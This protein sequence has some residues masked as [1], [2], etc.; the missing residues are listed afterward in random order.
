MGE[1]K[2]DGFHH[3]FTKGLLLLNGKRGIEGPGG[4]PGEAFILGGE[5]F[6]D[7]AFE[8]GFE[9]GENRRDVGA[10]AAGIELLDQRI[11]RCDFENFAAKL[12]FFA[13]ESHDAIKGGQKILPVSA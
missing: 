10:A 9:L 5:G 1:I 6:G 8:E 2:T 7:K 3:G 12:G 13:G 4:M 11:I